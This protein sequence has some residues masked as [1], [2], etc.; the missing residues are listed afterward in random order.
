MVNNFFYLILVKIV[1]YE[2]RYNNSQQKIYSMV[3]SFQNDGLRKLYESGKEQG[4]PRY[5]KEV[6]KA[7]VRKIDM[8]VAA[9]NSLALTKFHSLHFEK[10][11]KEEKY[12]GMHSIRVNDKFRIILKIVKQKDGTETVEIAEIHDLTDYH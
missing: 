1:C 9:E 5:G 11:V 4:K 2:D 8:V 12:R 10:L 7:F 6:I 3:V